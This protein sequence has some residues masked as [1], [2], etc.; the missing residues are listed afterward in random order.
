MA[1]TARQLGATQ[2]II[3]YKV[4]KYEIDPKKYTG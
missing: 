2:R 3:G 1:A 4:Q